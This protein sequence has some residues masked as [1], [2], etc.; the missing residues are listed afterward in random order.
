MPSAVTAFFGLR[1]DLRPVFFLPALLRGCA[2][3]GLFCAVLF[4]PPPFLL[5]CAVPALLFLLDIAIP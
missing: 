1:P 2:L 5:L 4:L 3:R